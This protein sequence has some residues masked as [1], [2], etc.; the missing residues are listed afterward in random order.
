[1]PRRLVR[2]DGAPAFKAPGRKYSD[3]AN[4]RI[5]A[6]IELRIPFHLRLEI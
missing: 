2:A 3:N 4:T 5:N 6:N 1:V